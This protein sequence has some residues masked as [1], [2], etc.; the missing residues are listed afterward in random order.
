MR[1]RTLRHSGFWGL[2]TVSTLAFI[3]SC[4]EKTA[5]LDEPLVNPSPDHGKV[6]LY[7][8]EQSHPDVLKTIYF[9]YDVAVLKPEAKN[10]LRENARWMKS[11][12]D[13]HLQIEGHCDE[14]GS[15]DYNVPLGEKRAQSAKEFF[16]ANGIEAERLSTISY[17]AILGQS[18]SNWG[19]NRKAD[20]IIV[21]PSR[22]AESLS[23][24]EELFGA[25]PY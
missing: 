4:S 21:Y 11:H 13:A 1:V 22:R 2:V 16:V 6:L 25:E 17:G 15:Q 12:P 14:R 10:W 3:F 24:S 7:Q 18:K 23:V 9:D 20:F 8:N 5:R 19:T